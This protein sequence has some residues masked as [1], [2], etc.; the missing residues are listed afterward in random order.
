MVEAFAQ[1][2]YV[3]SNLYSLAYR[4]FSFNTP[5]SFTLEKLADQAIESLLDKNLPSSMQISHK[6]KA[7]MP[8]IRAAILAYKQAP[9]E[10]NARRIMRLKKEADIPNAGDPTDDQRLDFSHL[11]L[12]KLDL[13]GIPFHGVSF[14][15]SDLY[16]AQIDNAG[17]CSFAHCNLKRANFTKAFLRGKEVN[18]QNANV[19]MARFIDIDLEKSTACA[20]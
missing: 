3:Y 6:A 8:S 16:A 12:R 13:R 2:T 9:T 5:D 7:A 1:I 14:A 19:S 11:N 18:F 10:A 4:V 15:Y 17:R 20:L